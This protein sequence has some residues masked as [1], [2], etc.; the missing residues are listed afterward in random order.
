MIT[1]NIF[2]AGMTGSGKSYF[3]Q[4]ML[5]KTNL[6]IIATSNK[7]EDYYQLQHLTNKKFTLV[8]VHENTRL[9]SLPR[10]NIFFSFGFITQ[11]KKIE[12]M[13]QLALHIMQDRNRIIYIDEAHEVLGEYSRYSKQLESLVAGGRARSLHII[14]VTQRPQNVKKSVI[15]N[16][17]W[18]ISFKLSE[19]NSVK[20]M[21]EHLEKVTEEDIKN[22]KLHEFYLYNA[23]DGT[24]SHNTP[25]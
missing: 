19:K 24:V 4:K 2:V 9:K 3:I 22:L 18:R 23:Y 10:K 12:F 17:K 20:A 25:V 16:C 11:D 8:E 13:D 14:V 15:N 21:S 1:I 5:E 7:I 6:P